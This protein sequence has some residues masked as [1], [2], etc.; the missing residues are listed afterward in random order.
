M[1]IP[2]LKKWGISMVKKIGTTI[3]VF[4]PAK[5]KLVKAGVLVK[6]IFIKTVNNKHFMR[7]ERGYGIQEKVLEELKPKMGLGPEIETEEVETGE[8]ETAEENKE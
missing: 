6:E 4:D 5:K 3:R 1:P 2:D 8:V 7:R